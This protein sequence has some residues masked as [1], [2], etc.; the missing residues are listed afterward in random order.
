MIKFNDL[1]S[2]DKTKRYRWT[3]EVPFFVL[4]FMLT[5]FEVNVMTI[6]ILYTTSMIF[7]LFFY[8]LI[9]NKRNYSVHNLSIDSIVLY[10][11]TILQIL[12]LTPLLIDAMGITFESSY[13]SHIFA[14]LV[15]LLMTHI[16]WYTVLMVQ[17]LYFKSKNNWKVKASGLFNS[18]WS[19]KRNDVEPES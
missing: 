19:F 7:G 9:N 12:F 4:L 6:G 8:G 17:K 11:I 16:F 15:S 13:Y 1:S 18:T 10:S 2:N 14:V 5:V 3:V